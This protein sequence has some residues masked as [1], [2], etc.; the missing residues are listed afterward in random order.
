[1]A[2]TQMLI[3]NTQHNL[4]KKTPAITTSH[5]S[6]TPPTHTTIPTNSNPTL[7]RF[8]QTSTLFATPKVTSSPELPEDVQLVLPEEHSHEE[9]APVTFCTYRVQLTFGLK[10]TGEVNVSQLFK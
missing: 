1:M 3:D 2:H 5:S 6:S 9:E 4:A 8:A 10:P 7:S